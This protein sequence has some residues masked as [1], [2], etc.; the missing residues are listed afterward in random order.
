MKYQDSVVPLM[1]KEEG[2]SG[3][4]E[5]DGSGV[6]V[7]MNGVGVLI[8]CKHNLRANSRTYFKCLGKHICLNPYCDE[9]REL[10]EASDPTINWVQPKCGEYLDHVIYRLE[11]NDQLPLAILGDAQDISLDDELDLITHK[12]NG[13]MVILKCKL[14]QDVAHIEING[15]CLAAQNLMSIKF[16]G[17]ETP[18]P[19]YSGG[20]VFHRASGKCMGILVLDGDNHTCQVLKATDFVNRFPS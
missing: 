9:Y 1:H 7:D 11:Y 16:T 20:G 15:K 10:P 17:V 2:G 18:I 12:S 4:E 13:E 5:Y 19:G 3:S 8:T 14:Y 6:L